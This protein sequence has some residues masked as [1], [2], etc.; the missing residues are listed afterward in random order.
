MTEMKI[1]AISDVHVKR[2]FDE[3]DKLL[4]SF[5]Q[6]RDVLSADIILFLGDI[7]DLMCGPH[8][9]YIRFFNHQFQQITE[10]SRA[11]KKIYFFEGNHDVHL[12]GLFKKIW[13]NNEVILS[14]KP[15]V[16][17]IEGKLYYYSH[18]DE[19]EVDNKSY[20]RYIRIIRSTPL[21]FIANNLMPYQLLSFLGERASKISRKKGAK[22][23]QYDLVRNRFRTGVT[24]STE[25]KFHFVLG[26]HSHV[27]DKFIIPNKESVYVNNGYALHTRTFILVENHEISFVPLL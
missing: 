11:G 9:E 8:Q 20:Q 13:K 19:H 5:L 6:H 18:G 23:F 22:S 2:P 12:D 14:Q 24:L 10:L 17:E 4:S 15:I 25:G 7:F 27:Q 3:A 16:E 21:K 26:G 1:V